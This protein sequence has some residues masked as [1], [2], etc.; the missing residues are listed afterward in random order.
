MT[1]NPIIQ[2]PVFNIKKFQLFLKIC[3]AFWNKMMIFLHFVIIN[4]SGWLPNGY[5]SIIFFGERI[6]S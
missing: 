4:H 5:K 3:P 1:L 6:L 2:Y